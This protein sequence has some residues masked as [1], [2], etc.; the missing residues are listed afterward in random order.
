MTKGNIFGVRLRAV[1][2]FA[3][4]T[5]NELADRAS[6]EPSAIS[7]FETGSRKPSLKI[8][9]HLPTLFRWPQI[10]FWGRD[11]NPSRR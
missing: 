2:L 1:R 9:A 8:C 4:Y 11:A 10:F 7:H 5:Q 3:G 6:F